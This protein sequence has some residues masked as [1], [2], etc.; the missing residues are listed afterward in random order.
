MAT[1]TAKTEEVKKLTD[2][3]LQ[4][5]YEYIIDFNGTQAAIRAKYSTKSAKEQASR[6]LTYDNVQ[7]KITELTQQRQARASKSADDVIAELEHIGF[8]RLG[9]I[10]T[11]DETGAAFINDSN[12]IPDCAEAAIESIQVDVDQIGND[13]NSR[14]VL[15]TKVKLHPKIPALIQLCKHHGI[16]NDKSQIELVGEGGGPINVNIN[17]VGPDK[18]KK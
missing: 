10:M 7:A 18:D 5:C 4:F 8:S 1:K 14:K 12:E 11:W 9:D 2:Q 13:K 16:A 3:Q 15:K 17:F 6:L